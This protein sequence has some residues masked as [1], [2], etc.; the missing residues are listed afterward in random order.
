MNS[1]TFAIRNVARQML[2]YKWQREGLRP[3][4]QKSLTCRL[5]RIFDS[6]VLRLLYT[7]L[8][9]VW[10]RPESQLS[11]GMSITSLLS[12]LNSTSINTKY[13]A[14][15]AV[16]GTQVTAISLYNGVKINY[17]LRS[18]QRVPVMYW[19]WQ[20]RYALLD[21]SRSLSYCMTPNAVIRQ[22]NNF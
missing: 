7:L 17:R 5:Q 4:L 13:L 10:T 15:L 2:P 20:L 3:S 9:P 18:V 11:W 8:K 22:H 6:P 1:E 19:H 16:P 14:S 12:S 21:V